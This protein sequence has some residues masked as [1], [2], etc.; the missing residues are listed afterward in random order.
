MIRRLSLC[1]L[2]SA[3]AAPALQ[4]QQVAEQALAQATLDGLQARSIAE[5]REYCGYIGY[6][7]TGALRVTTAVAGSLDG[8]VIPDPPKNWI[9]AASYH[10]HGSYDYE[11]DSEVPSIDDM[12]GDLEEGV[13]GYISTPGG[14]LWMIDFRQERA[15]MLCDVG[16][17]TADPNFRRDP[18]YLPA[19]SYTLF[20]LYARFDEPY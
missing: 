8:C 14:R 2:L 6:D 15:Q 19:Q 11:Y 9:V 10:T 13:D 5:Q 1:L 4:P 18:E 3:C 16:C 20:E 7:A 12:I 17:V